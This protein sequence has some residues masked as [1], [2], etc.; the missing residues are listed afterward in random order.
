MRA[1]SISNSYAGYYLPGLSGAY[2]FCEL[3][4]RLV[5][6]TTK[7]TWNFRQICFAQIFLVFFSETQIK[8]QSTDNQRPQSEVDN[9][10]WM[11]RSAGH[12]N[13]PQW[14]GI[15]RSLVFSEILKPDVTRSVVEQNWMQG[16]HY[17]NQPFAVV[18]ALVDF[19]PG[20]VAGVRE[21]CPLSVLTSV[22]T[23]ILSKIIKEWRMSLF[24]I[25]GCL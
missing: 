14:F 4:F 16:W 17:S 18:P 11:Q 19:V 24:I 12:V 23:C 13:K 15:A 25:S 10:L 1:E 3:I 21:T 6:S 7:S 22:C 8:K 2:V 5:H 20:R 9:N